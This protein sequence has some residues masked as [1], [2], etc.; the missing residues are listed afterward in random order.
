M[1]SWWV[2]F[3]CFAALTLRLSV[4]R[5]C[6]D[7]YD[8][9]PALMSRPGWAWPLALLYLLAHVWML[10]VSLVTVSR[11]GEL[12][13][14]TLRMWGNHAVKLLLMLGVFVIEYAPVSLWRLIGTSLQ[15]TR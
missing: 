8:L 1:R 3:P 13:A 4:E 11:A 12:R 5:A 2:I 9:L 15:C 10:A 7:P 14:G 6:S